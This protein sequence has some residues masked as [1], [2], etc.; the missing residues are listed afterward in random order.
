VTT[1]IVVQEDPQRSP[2]RQHIALIGCC[3]GSTEIYLINGDGS[4]F[5]QIT[6]DGLP[7]S[8]LSWQP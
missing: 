1:N 2:D 4:H 6:R 5:R 8:N 3:A 7:R